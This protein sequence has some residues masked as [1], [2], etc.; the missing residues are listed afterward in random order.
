MSSVAPASSAIKP[1]YVRV[2]Q[3]QN[4]FGFSKSH[5]YRLVDRGEIRLRKFGSIT[6]VKVEEVEALIDAGDIP[7][8]R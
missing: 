3:V 8:E 1:V 7:P 6:L 2:G 5:L 4:V